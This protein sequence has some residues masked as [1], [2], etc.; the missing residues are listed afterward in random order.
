M[1]KLDK[2]AKSFKIFTYVSLF[3]TSAYFFAHL[4]FLISEAELITPYGELEHSFFTGLL[5]IDMVSWFV[6]VPFAGIVIIVQT[7][8]LIARLADTENVKKWFYLPSFLNIIFGTFSIYGI[9]ELF[10]SAV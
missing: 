4:L 3:I 1:K 6:Y 10:K 7:L 2:E 9:F 8:Y 5:L